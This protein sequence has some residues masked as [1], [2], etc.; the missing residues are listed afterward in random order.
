M[1]YYLGPCVTGG[2][3]QLAIEIMEERG[4]GGRG[5]R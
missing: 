1:K 5:H 3:I 2:V 4:T